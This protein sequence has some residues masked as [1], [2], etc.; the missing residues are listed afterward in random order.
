MNETK[1]DEKQNILIYNLQNKKN[2]RFFFSFRFNT[3]V[4]DIIKKIF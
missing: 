2:E 3:L 4:N 1:L